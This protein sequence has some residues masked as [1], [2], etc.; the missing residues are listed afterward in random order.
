MRVYS[1]VQK[2]LIVSRQPIQLTL[3]LY[4]EKHIAKVRT[5][6]ILTKC[7]AAKSAEFNIF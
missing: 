3:N 6:Y 1:E 4:H 2:K 5:L 7:F